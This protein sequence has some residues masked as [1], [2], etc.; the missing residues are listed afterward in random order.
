[1]RLRHRDGTTVHVAYCTNVHPAEDLAGVVGQLRRY[2]LPVRERLGVPL[3]GVG[4]WLAADVAAALAAEPDAAERLRDELTAC[5]LE[6]VTLNAFPYQGF[7]APKVKHAVYRPDWTERDRLTYTVNCARALATLLPEDVRRGSISTVPLAWR[8]PWDVD[9]QAIAMAQIDD[10]AG[11]LRKIAEVT[12]RVIRLGLEPEPGCIVETTEQAVE[13]LA[14]VARDVIGVCLDACHVATAFEQPADALR[15]LA[16]GDLEIV[17]LQAS[18]ALHID[19][20]IAGRDALERFREERFLHQVRSPAGGRDDLDLALEG[21]GL[22]GAPWR[23][24]FHVPLHADPPPPLR[25]T[26]REL[27]D[28]LGLMFGGPSAVTDHVEVETYTWSVLPDAPT[29]D[30][31]L[32]AGIAA[33]LA[34]TRERLISHGLSE[35]A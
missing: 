35:D 17:K 15:R 23:V 29:D 18:A 3:L 10:L 34:W 25:T 16:G 21:S 28:L 8:E 27:D 19:D 5:G 4:L 6:V 9:R 2:A 14:A 33:E 7:Q 30:A 31:G 11:E 24:H 32:I 12:G 20:P 1:V 22:E 13:R 26:R